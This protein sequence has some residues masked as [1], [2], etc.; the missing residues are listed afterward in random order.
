MST[1]LLYTSASV[2]GAISFLFIYWKKMRHDYTRDMVFASGF[3]ILLLVISM[4][5]ISIYIVRYIPATNIFDSTQ[6][7][8]WG[9]LVGY[10]IAFGLNIVNSKFKFFESLEASG[11]GLF[12][13]LGFIFVANGINRRDLNSLLASGLVIGLFMIYLI[14]ERKYRRFTWYKSGRVGFAGLTTLGLFFLI[15][16]MVSIYG[17]SMLSLAGRVEV[18]LSSVLAFLLFFSVYHLSE[19]Y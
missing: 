3:S 11:I 2:L 15:R 17:G 6:L 9:A 8:F 1:I 19:R 14:L 16:S 12:I 5:F 10:L 7:W 13:W 4:T 18:V